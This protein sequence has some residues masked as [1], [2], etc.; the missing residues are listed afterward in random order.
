MGRVQHP[1]IHRGE[2]GSSGKLGRLGTVI[3]KGRDELKWKVD[4]NIWILS[5]R[6]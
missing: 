2:V 1:P 3:A 5:S 6:L 4:Q